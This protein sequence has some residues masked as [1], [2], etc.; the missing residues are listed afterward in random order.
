MNNKAA[1]DAPNVVHKYLS[2]QTIDI[3]KTVMVMV[4]F[5]L[6]QWKKFVLPKSKTRN[7]KPKTQNP[8]Y[9]TPKP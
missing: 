8:K 6:T 7:P 1:V 9:T 5:F 2:R 3:N 4:T